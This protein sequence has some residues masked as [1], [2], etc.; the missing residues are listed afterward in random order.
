MSLPGPDR[1]GMQ[2]QV[3]DSIVRLLGSVPC[4]GPY[5]PGVLLTNGYRQQISDRQSGKAWRQL[6]IW[7]VTGP[8]RRCCMRGLATMIPTPSTWPLGWD[9]E[10]WLRILRKYPGRVERNQNAI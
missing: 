9:L 8:L 6:L 5:G 7:R 2:S 4:L 1:V 3:R 10:C